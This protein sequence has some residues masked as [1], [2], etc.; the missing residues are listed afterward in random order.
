MRLVLYVCLTIALK[1]IF[2]NM[3]AVL[4]ISYYQA[5]SK[6]HKH[7]VQTLNPQLRS[8]A[9]TNAPKIIRN[10]TQVH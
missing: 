3:A 5:A 2:Q 6:N 8:G 7:S 9:S 1:N 4:K 10:L